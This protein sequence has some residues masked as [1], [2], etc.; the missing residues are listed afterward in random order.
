MS[1]REEQ[2]SKKNSFYRFQE[3]TQMMQI[4][5]RCLCTIFSPRSFYGGAT[6]DLNSNPHPSSACHLLT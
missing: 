4:S 5:R 6:A 3:R 2:Q 1:C